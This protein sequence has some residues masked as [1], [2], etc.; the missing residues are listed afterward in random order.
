MKSFDLHGPAVSE[1]GEYV[2]AAKDLHSRACYMIYG[3]LGPGEADRL[4]K[5]GEGHEEILCAV[6][7]TLV[8]HTAAGEVPLQAGSALHVEANESFCLSNPS[9]RPVVYITAGGRLHPHRSCD[10]TRPHGAAPID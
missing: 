2:L 1:G 10:E 3:I 8:I 9:D 4:V 7:G 5:P 6:T